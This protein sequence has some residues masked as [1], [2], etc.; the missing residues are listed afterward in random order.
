M[1]G[2]VSA[3]VGLFGAVLALVGGVGLI[4]HS[5]ELTM[6][7]QEYPD[8]MLSVL[9]TIVGLNILWVWDHYECVGDES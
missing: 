7:T 1:G 8:A 3:L 6:A 2:V 5:N 9:A 4:T